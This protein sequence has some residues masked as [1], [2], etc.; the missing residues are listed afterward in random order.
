MT[1]PKTTQ[2]RKKLM[3]VMVI[4]NYL[5]YLGGAEL[6]AQQL[7]RELVSRG[8]RVIILT[9]GR[10][11]LSEK[12]TIDGVEVARLPVL[13]ITQ[14]SRLNYLAIMLYLHQIISFCKRHRAEIDVVHSHGIGRMALLLGKRLH[15]MGIPYVVKVPTAG[16]TSILGIGALSFAQDFLQDVNGFIAVGDDIF[17]ELKIRRVAPE[18]IYRIPNGVDTNRFCPLPH[19]KKTTL[20]AQ[21]SLPPGFLC[22]YTGRLIKRKGLEFLVDTWSTIITS[23][24]T[25]L[26]VIIGSGELQPDSIEDD[27]LLMVKEKKLSNHVYLPGK[28]DDV[29]PY[30][31]ASDCFIFTSLREGMPNSVLEAMSCGLPI[32]VA[33]TGGHV[34]LITPDKEGIIVPFGKPKEL[35]NAVLSLERKPALRA[36]L[37]KGARK[38]AVAR[39]SIKQ[40]TDM[41]EDLYWKLGS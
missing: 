11:G 39:Y 5:P 1:T 9:R 28:K 40:I 4:D 26:L 8:H 7:G 10:K 27:L 3:I 31:Q 21:L 35:A 16:D 14:T 15:K 25:A 6:Q 37:G 23:C 32:I 22:V 19:A 29:S 34:S 13:N 30:I 20:R 38:K 18:K 33:A 36:L 12:E 2:D 17:D 41:Y 24:P